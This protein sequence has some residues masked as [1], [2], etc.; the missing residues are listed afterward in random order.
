MKKT[1]LLI[2]AVAMLLPLASCKKDKTPA[3]ETTSK[4]YTLA[5]S[6]TADASVK[7][8][9]SK[10]DKEVKVKLDD[11][12]ERIIKSVDF[13]ASG[14]YVAELKGVETEKITYEVG[15]YRIKDTKAAV[16]V[17]Y[18][19]TLPTGEVIEMSVTVNGGD[20]NISV[21]VGDTTIETTV[22]VSNNIAEGADAESF[23]KKVAN[24]AWKVSS[25][26]ITASGDG[27]SAEVNKL[28]EGN[29]DAKVIAEWAT[30]KG[31]KVNSEKLDGYTVKNIILS[32]AGTFS[33]SFTGKDSFTGKLAGFK[34]EG[35][36]G[37]FGYSFETF[38]EKFPLLDAEASGTLEFDGNT[39]KLHLIGEPSYD[40][41]NY[42]V[43]LLFKL[44]A[45]I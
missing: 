27:L 18:L 13:T 37:V 17:T 45:D 8:D 42:K 39:L 36:K 34:V 12:E 24:N 2:A 26:Q 22:T 35:E 25:T 43:D 23:M 14:K 33:I 20:A 3:G 41:K 19:I 30:E 16:T 28:F 40:G 32:E 7:L 44:E 4:E 31:I 11:G 9:L 15:D 1:L 6:A 21:T 5:K 10:S 38:E 29:L